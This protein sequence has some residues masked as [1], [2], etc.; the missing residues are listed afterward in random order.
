MRI[1]IIGEDF[2][3]SI[4]VETSDMRRDAL[5]LQAN[6]PSDREFRERFCT[7]LAEEIPSMLYRS[8]DRGLRTP[9]AGLINFA[10]EVART[11]GIG[12]PREALR[13]RDGMKLFLAEH[14]SRYN[15]CKRVRADGTQR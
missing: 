1:R 2:D 3:W 15:E 8:V 10:V 12:I 14:V 9:D 7:L 6:L 13:Y 5:S 11:L 4:D